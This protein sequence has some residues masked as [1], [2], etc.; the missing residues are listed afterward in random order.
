MT[1]SFICCFFSMLDKPLSLWWFQ[2]HLD[3]YCPGTHIQDK[4]FFT[5]QQ[6]PYLR[7]ALAW[8][9][10]YEERAKKAAQRAS[11]LFSACFHD[12]DELIILV[13]DYTNPQLFWSNPNYLYELL[14]E[15]TISGE[16]Q[17]THHY[18]TAYVLNNEKGEPQKI[19]EDLQDPIPVWIGV[20]HIKKNKAIIDA[21]LTWIA[22]HELWFDPFLHQSIHFY[23]PVNHTRFYMYDDRGCSISANNNW[24]LQ[25]LYERY[26]G[27]IVD[28]DKK[29]IDGFFT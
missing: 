20:Y 5:Q 10:S 29:T 3:I 17:K 24:P 1:K 16:K 14:K 26:N 18:R 12:C 27:W 13:Y 15:I 23:N 28:Y 19:I 9:W 25:H 21:I 22:N 11:A 8:E 2:T 7:F 6:R 4:I